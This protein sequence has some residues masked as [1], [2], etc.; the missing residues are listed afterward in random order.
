MTR[1]ARHRRAVPPRGDR[2]PPTRPLKP[3]RAPKRR[4]RS[5]WSEIP[6]LVVIAVVLTV[7]IQAFVAR[8]FVIPSSSMEQT[9]LGCSGCT[10]DRVITDRVAYR[11]TDPR[12]GDVVVF[13][14]PPAWR[15]DDADTEATD[16]PSSNPLSR[17]LRSVAS[18]FGAG[19]SEETDFVKRVIAVGGQTVAC[20][21]PQ[22]RVTVNGRAI[23]EPYLYFQ[24]GRGQVQEPFAPV[25]VP[26]GQ[27]WVMGDNRN[28][29]ADAR[30][31]GA[32]PVAALIGKV[33]AVVLPITRW[34]LVPGINPQAAATEPSPGDE[35][36][37]QV[38]GR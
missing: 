33:R 9:L 2:S 30:V 28:N 3:A 16:E 13:E 35:A 10:N 27:L 24:P 17:A 14:G 26:D 18:L 20:C 29:S 37:E 8:I 12:P 15:A 19:S 23:S 7:L 11:F 6:G 25:R 38:T 31:H 1:H 32:V 5:F 36:S 21:D 4:R 22:N 34:R